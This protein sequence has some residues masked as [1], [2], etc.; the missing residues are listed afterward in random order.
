MQLRFFN[1]IFFDRLAVV[2]SMKLRF[3]KCVFFGFVT[4][5]SLNIHAQD[6]ASGLVACYSF[7][8]NATD[9]SG[10]S[11][12]GV[13]SNA[14]LI[15][16]RFGNANSAYLFS[17]SPSS[18]ISFPSNAF[19]I[20]EYS[21]S[22]WVNASSFPGAGSTGIVL[23]VGDVV[24][25]RQTTLNLGNLYSS[26]QFLGWGGGSWNDAPIPN[27]SSVAQGA[28]P[29]LNEWYHLVLTRSNTHVKLYINGQYIG[30]DAT[31]GYPAY[32]GT[33]TNAF[34]GV[35][36]NYTQP[37]N[38]AIDDMSVYNRE[39]TQQEVTLLYQNGMACL[40]S[41]A[42]PNVANV[43]IC[44]PGFATLVASGG[45]QYRWYDSQYGGTLLF[46]GNPFLTPILTATKS[47]Y[48]SNVDGSESGRKKVMVIVNPTPSFTC[49]TAN[50]CYLPSSAAI[51]VNVTQG[52]PP[53]NFTFVFGDGTQLQSQSSV[54]QHQ[55]T[56]P[57]EYA[58]MVSAI[59][60]KNCQSQCNV[61]VKVAPPPPVA[62]D[63]AICGSASATLTASGGSMY[64]WYDSQY[65]GNLLFEG[66]PFI[67]PVLTTTKSYYVSNFNSYESTRSKVTVVVNP[68]PSFTCAN[69]NM[70]YLPSNS[71]VSVNV[72]QGSPPFNFTFFFGDGTQIQTQSS[73]VQHQYAQPGDYAL[74]VTATDAKN[75]QSQC[76]GIVKVA[77][78]P[79]V[80][81]DQAICGPATATLTASGGS[82][83]KWYDAPIGGNLLFS[84]SEFA[85]PVLSATTDYYVSNLN[86]YESN[87]IKA[88]VTV[89]PTPTLA[90][91]P[92]FTSFK[93]EVNIAITLASGTG[94]F[95][96]NY[97]FGDGFNITSSET[98]VSHNFAEP[99]DYRLSIHVIDSKN[100]AVSCVTPLE[101]ITDV[102]I[103]NVITVND[104]LKNDL[105]N[106]F[107]T[108]GSSYL[109]YAGEEKFSLLVIDRWGHPI[110]QTTDP[111]EGWNGSG[112][113]NGIYYYLISIGP[114]IYRGCVSVRY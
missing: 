104:D 55:Y 94:P 53:F 45:N 59:D 87:R 83:Y 66:N 84:G 25:S 75:C 35:R 48:V 10:N 16:D 56:Q 99:G 90:C 38:G 46:E 37:Y 13:V 15:A 12:D 54:V 101:V 49:S 42:M 58:L 30:S 102:F 81:L 85:T 68:A 28:I 17:G 64:K 70:H 23:S 2:L 24:T 62:L 91:L 1:L 9:G 78:P 96:I 114:N 29:N 18:Y 72:T 80:V 82:F 51:S 65:D 61:I 79:P 100:C 106:L 39:V 26:G 60:A 47:Y 86:Y 7:S 76:D 5:V 41:I 52:S 31:Y 40:P 32:Y 20:N 109:K 3:N 88:S 33:T 97:D 113:S 50:I 111:A 71:E 34:I 89:N 105:F 67:T 103:P 4:L 98:A 108:K 110:Y 22:M 107:F 93:R 36:C 92:D 43:E 19:K 6:L 73:V 44:S 21:Y 11:L 8:G 112:V 74:S 57:G 63:Q 77:P 95:S 27:T 69:A 14:T